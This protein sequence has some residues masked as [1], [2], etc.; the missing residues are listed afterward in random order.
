M[1]TFD[2]FHI[3]PPGLPNDGF[4]FADHSAQR[5]SGH[6][7][8]ALL[9]CKNGEL[10]AYYPNCNDDNAGHSGN[11]WMEFRRSTDHGET[12]DTTEKDAYS[13]KMWRSHCGRT[14]M[15]E[16]GVT[17]D[18]GALVIFHLICDMQENGSFWEP[19]WI[20]T[21]M[22]SIDNGCTW[23][24]AQ[25][26]CAL[27][28]RVYD[29]RYHEGIIYALMFANDATEHFV[30]VRPEHEY[31]LYVS[32]DDGLTFQ[33]RSVLSIPSYHRGYGCMEFMS[34]GDL[35]AYAYD[36]DD[37]SHPDY[38]ISHDQG[39]TWDAP[40]KTH[41]AKCI[42][43]PQIVRF[44]GGYF[45]HGRSGSLNSTP[46]HFVLYYSNDAI[47]WDEGRYM[48]LCT[49]GAGAYSNNLVV[50]SHVP[51]MQ[52]RLLI[53]TSHAYSEHRTNTIFWWIDI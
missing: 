21:Y 43:N 46:G 44:G 41:V 6:L 4:L 5:R 19:Y 35:I 26:L 20:P 34:N 18:S 8:H 45:M 52:K 29:A 33:L 3:S 10:L 47:H 22:R 15:C 30:G 50:G 53:H 9:E 17:T 23:S 25:D 31:Q 24:Q 13:Y 28:G 2:D 14:A 38:C 32:L 42:R 7:G 27:R 16:K 48:R 39:H 37:E 51:G 12:W 11:G 36:I 1:K 49:E 40:R